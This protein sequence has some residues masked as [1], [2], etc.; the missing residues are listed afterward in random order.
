LLKLIGQLTNIK[1]SSGWF[2]LFAVAAVAAV[3]PAALPER[4]AYAQQAAADQAGAE[5]LNSERIERRYGS[6]GVEVLEASATLRVSNL[7]SLEDG[8]RV[9]RTFAVVLYPDAIDPAVAEEH[10][11]IVAG[12]SIGATFAQRGWQVDKSHRH[13]GTTRA[14]PKVAALMSIA[15]GTEL[16]VHVY[17]LAAARAETSIRYATIVEIH[18]PDYL[19]VG[20]LIAIYGSA[21]SATDRE[22]AALL[23][24]A[25]AKMR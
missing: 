12:G 4:T 24:A 16:A 13:F 1:A 20:A 7:Y 25:I 21:P 14:T 2:V 22:T 5:L 6:Y 3:G 8:G 23:E 19:D 10:R 11:L 9:C 17:G 15:P 18:H